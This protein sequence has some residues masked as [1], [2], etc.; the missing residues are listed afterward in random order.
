MSLCSSATAPAMAINEANHDK[1]EANIHKEET[2]IH[3]EEASVSTKHQ[4]LTES[5]I[6]LNE[7]VVTGLTGSQK[8]KQ[9]PAPISF[10]SARQL[11]M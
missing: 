7:V 9:S 8:L 5:S 2:N 4:P 10:V 1:E 3:E 6:K 11:E